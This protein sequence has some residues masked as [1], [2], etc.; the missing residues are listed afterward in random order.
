MKTCLTKIL[1]V[2]ALMSASFMSNTSNAESNIIYAPLV[3]ISSNELDFSTNQFGEDSGSYRSLT[4]GMLT[5]VEKWT[6]RGSISKPF[7]DTTLELNPIFG[8][9]DINVENRDINLAYAVTEN[10]SAFAGYLNNEFNFTNKTTLSNLGG[11]GDYLTS[12]NE[13]GP[14]VGASYRF[15]FSSGSINLSAAYAYLDS[16]YTDNMYEIGLPALI[17]KGETTGFSYNIS[18]QGSISEQLKYNLG[19]YQRK[20]SYDSNLLSGL[21]EFPGLGQ[22]TNKS[23]DSDWD[24]TTLSAN[25]IYVFR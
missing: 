10:V 5:Q 11:T 17:T 2:G 12:Y 21:P 3:G 4:V 24:I 19:L 14:Y 18:W 22:L 23:F 20:Y 8:K 6:L 7:S 15:T 13:L 16:D 1:C 9:S 25:I